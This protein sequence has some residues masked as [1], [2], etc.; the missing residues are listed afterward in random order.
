MK[1]TSEPS[2]KRKG[3]KQ[4]RLRLKGPRRSLP[5]AWICR[6]GRVKLQASSS[7]R[8]W[9]CDDESFTRIS[10]V[11]REQLPLAP[12]TQALGDEPWRSS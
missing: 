7:G 6:C 8:C 10:S 11:A 5:R 2:D 1:R 3:Q 12:G 9:W 4:L